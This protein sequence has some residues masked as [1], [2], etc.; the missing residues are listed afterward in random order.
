MYT[1][2][3]IL[4]CARAIMPYLHAL[5]PE[6]SRDVLAEILLAERSND[7]SGIA[8]AQALTQHPSTRSWAKTFL[9]TGVTRDVTRSSSI[10]GHPAPVAVEWF[11]CSACGYRW[12]A[13]ESGEQVPLCPN[14]HGALNPVGR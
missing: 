13:V 3:D 11:V 4:L 10:P 9:T 5:L 2:D 6:D 1:K 7:D 12:A 8:I 14:R